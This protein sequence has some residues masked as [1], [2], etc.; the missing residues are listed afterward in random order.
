MEILTERPSLDDHDF[1]T[2]RQMCGEAQ[3]WARH[4][5]GMVVNA[6]VLVVTASLIFLGLAFDEGTPVNQSVMILIVPFVMSIFGLFLTKMLYKLY[7]DCISRM[8][9]LENLLNCYDAK[10]YE[11]IDNRSSLLLVYLTEISKP[12]SVSFFQRQ[13]VLLSFVYILFILV[14]INPLSVYNKIF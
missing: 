14:K 13:H 1:G 7:C 3:Q 11:K 2:I 10:K 8:I 6:N 4:Y 12:A 5:T 9:R